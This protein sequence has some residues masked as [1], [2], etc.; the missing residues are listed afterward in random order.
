MKVMLAVMP[1]WH[2]RFFAANAVRP[3]VERLVLF[4]AG[5]LAGFPLARCCRPA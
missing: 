4:S 5:G 3:S 1:E 2:P